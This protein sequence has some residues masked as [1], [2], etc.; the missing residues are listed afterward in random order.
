MVSI[1]DAEGNVVTTNTSSVTLAIGTN[2]G[3]GALSCTTNPKPA[4]AGVAT[5]AGCKIS[6]A[7]TGYTLTATDGSLTATSATFNV[8]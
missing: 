2:P 8:T 3:V 6:L 4:V 7:G 1:E 5:F